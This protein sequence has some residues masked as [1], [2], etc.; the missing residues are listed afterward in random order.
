M[1]VMGRKYEYEGLSELCKA[2]EI[3]TWKESLT[4]S[5]VIRKDKFEN[6]QSLM[7]RLQAK[8]KIR[9]INMTFAEIV[10]FQYKRPLL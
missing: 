1:R 2:E 3:A 6:M 8:K 9:Y 4:T 7:S 5:G 10:S